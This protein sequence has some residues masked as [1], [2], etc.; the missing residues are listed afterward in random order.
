VVNN[1]VANAIKFTMRGH[2][3]LSAQ[4]IAAAGGH[5]L[6]VVRIDDSGPGV[7]PAQRERIFE[8]FVQGDASLTRQ[9]GGSGLGLPIARR[10]ARAMGGDVTLER[11][12]SDGSTFAFSWP[13]QVAPGV[14][15]VPPVEPGLAWLVY[16]RADSGQ[17]LQRRLARLDWRSEVLSDIGAVIGR[18]ASTSAGSEP[19][20]IVLS[21]SVLSSDT[22]FAA[23]RKAWPQ[24]RIVLLV[25]ADWDQPALESAASAHGAQALVPPLTPQALRAML[26]APPTASGV[27]ASA[28][29]AP[30]T[31][32][33]RVLVVEDNAVNL[34]I[35]EEFV[36]Q[37]GHEPAGATD[38]AQA[39]TACQQ[40]APELVLMDLQMPVMDGFETT[41]RLRALQADGRLPRFP[42]VA[43]SAHAGDH[44]RRQ[45]AAA[46]MDD[47]LTKP[48]L[49]DALRSALARWLR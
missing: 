12:G 31:R 9:H 11:S 40:L 13:A 15:P 30:T 22:D 3:A 37:L 28:G 18:A 19:A 6:V 20:V 29:A 26:S 42:I 33:A 10:L 23:L 8:P 32:G 48:I 7:A 21:E 43:L 47:Y 45:G 14:V 36:R 34:M 49:V 35:T 17:W 4:L 5:A 46:G 39:I 1:L 24:A 2:V 44:D 38:G 25:R 27:G 41:R 16:R